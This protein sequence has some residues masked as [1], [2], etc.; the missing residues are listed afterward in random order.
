MATIHNPP[1]ER[2]FDELYVFLSEDENG[3]GLVASVVPGIGAAL[4]VTGS[5][6]IA[7]HFKTIAAGIA[8]ETG[9]RIIMH[10][11]TRGEELWSSMRH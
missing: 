5:P 7:E 8:K 1:N 2:A 4:L 6:T 3:H 11:F 9:K 10:K